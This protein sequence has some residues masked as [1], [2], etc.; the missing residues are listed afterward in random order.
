MS[1]YTLH[2]QFMTC[3]VGM[4]RVLLG[5]NSSASGGVA[6]VA[7]HPKRTHFAVAERGVDPCIYIYNYPELRVVRILRKG[8]E[9]GYADLQFSH[10]GEKLATIGT[11]PGS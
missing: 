5:Y 8:A 3:H 11:E 9:R 4:Q 1:L 6:A 7:V 2:A 10:T